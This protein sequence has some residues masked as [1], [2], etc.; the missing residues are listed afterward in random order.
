MERLPYY[1]M[2]ELTIEDIISG[3]VKRLLMEKY[4]YDILVDKLNDMPL[5]D[6]YPLREQ[7]K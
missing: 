3:R 5:L 7:V 1:Q 2:P 6:L 4:Y